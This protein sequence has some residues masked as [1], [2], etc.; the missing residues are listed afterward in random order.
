MFDTALLPEVLAGAPDGIVVVD[1][2]GVVHYANRQ[3]TSLFG[4]DLAEVTGQQVEMLLPERFHRS[5][6]DHRQAFRQGPRVRPMGAGQELLARRKDGSEFPVDICLSQIG[7][8][9]QGLVAA[10]IRD[11]TDRHATETRLREARADADRASQSKSRFLATASHD[12]RQPLQALALLNGALR[13]SVHDPAALEAI[14]QQGKAIDAMSRLLAALLDISKLESGATQAQ[15]TGFELG[16]LLMELRNQFRVLAADK[17]LRLEMD[18]PPVRVRT[19][20][21]LLK[22]VLQNLLGNAIKYTDR[23]LVCVRYREG[24]ESIRLD[25]IDTGVGINAGDL[26]RIFDEFFQAGTGSEAARQG[27][28]LGLS[29]VQH[30]VR[31]LGLHLTVKSEP[32][33]G[34]TFTLELPT[35]MLEGGRTHEGHPGITPRTEAPGHCEILLVEDD[36]AVRRATQIFLRSQG[37]GVTAA[38]S[39]AEALDCSARMPAIDLILADYHLAGGRGTEVISAIRN[40]V[41]SLIPSILMTGDTSQ[42]IREP[43]PHNRLRVISKPVDAEAL[44]DLIGVLT[45]QAPT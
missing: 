30:I 27:H 36:P 26:P 6:I 16:A 40:L 29:I 23:G 43:P 14:E 37:Y 13:R 25:I 24:T 33:T 42:V 5:H 9:N 11:A 18:C 12:L 7:P 3:V 28:G 39:P 31:L 38:A 41:G 8:E 45:N 32:G 35:G 44:L 15:I 22:Q 17:G 1:A 4:Y 2:A 19:D 21:L 20:R 10:A 34:S